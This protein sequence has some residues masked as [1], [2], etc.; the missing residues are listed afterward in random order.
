MCLIQIGSGS[1]NYDT[2]VQDGFTNFIIKNNIEDS[3][4]IV[5]ANSIHLENLKKYWENK[6]NVKI[7]NFA[8]IPDN[9]QKEKM[10][11]FYS[12]NDS[13]NYQIFSNSKVFVEKHFPKGTIKEKVISCIKI[14]NFLMQIKLQIL[15]LIS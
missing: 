6:K 11:F 2:Y 7:F 10:T 9:I 3:I 15:I 14:S 12:L 4:F 5:E 1:G 13:P 8:I